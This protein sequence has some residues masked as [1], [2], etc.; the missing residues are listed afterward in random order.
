MVAFIVFS[1]LTVL[2][3]AAAMTATDASTGLWLRNPLAWI[4]ALAL[5]AGLYRLRMPPAWTLGLLAAVLA[6][7]LFAPGQAG[8]HRWI[9][10]GPVQL[11]VAA[12]VTPFALVL[13]DRVVRQDGRSAYAI[14]IAAMAG[15]LAWQPDMSQLGALV[16]AL[17]VWARVQ[18][19][20]RALRWIVPIAL[21]L[22]L[23]CASRPDPLDAVTYV[24]GILD[25]AASVSPMLA[26]A[27]G[28]CL[29]LTCLSPLAL[30]RDVDRRPVAAALAAY[31]VVSGFAWLFGAFPV[32]LAGYGLSFILGWMVG[33]TA[34]LMK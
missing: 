5:C 9:G 34:L 20:G 17:L 32:P 24:E 33:A 27:C 16:A 6:L 1:L 19:D 22:L 4:V 15:I 23:V 29:L 7:S 13:A 25:L 30:A 18:R 21:A 10:I 14:A 3:G 11:N 8:V 26:L 2:L 28:L 12:L 31:F